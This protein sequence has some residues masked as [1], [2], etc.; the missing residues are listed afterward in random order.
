MSWN[1]EQH[2]N[3]NQTLERPIGTL[4]WFM[5][6]NRSYIK[7]T[8]TPFYQRRRG[9]EK[10]PLINQPPC[11]G[12]VFQI[13]DS[14]SCFDQIQ[15]RQY[16]ENN[17]IRCLIKPFKFAVCR[18]LTASFMMQGHPCIILVFTKWPREHHVLIFKL[19]R[20]VKKKPNY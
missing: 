12:T 2:N 10:E 1:D 20:I 17:A 7:E 14:T 9:G 4:L 5:L 19:I 18:F 11:T 15:I 3:S 13:Y 8:K 16:W 6:S